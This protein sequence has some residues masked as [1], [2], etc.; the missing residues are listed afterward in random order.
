MATAV[1]TEQPDLA[2]STDE[3][4]RR[5]AGAVGHYFLDVQWEFVRAFLPAPGT[6]RILDVGGGHAQLAQPLVKLGYDVTVFGSNDA[7]IPRLDREVGAGKYHY[8]SGDLLSLPLDSDSFDIVLAFRLLPHLD[9]WPR[10]LDEVTRVASKSVVVDFPDLCSVNW[11]SERLFAAKAMVEDNTR[12][13]RCFHQ[14]EIVDRLTTNEF[15][16]IELQGQFLFPMAIHRLM[17]TR[18]LS[19]SLERVARA[20]GMTERFGS[21]VILKASR[22]TG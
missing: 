9:N 5:F 18:I 22:K 14:R 8:V 11:F 13:Y 19:E 15:C 10:F 4:A 7:C 3:Y 16:N 12:H 2:S 20:T 21:P 17:R 6:C 1:Q